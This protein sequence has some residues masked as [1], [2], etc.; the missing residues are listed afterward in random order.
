V[1]LAVQQANENLAE[2]QLLSCTM[3]VDDRR[4]PGAELRQLYLAADYPLPRRTGG[5]E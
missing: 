2:R 5:S 3:D 1:A 4:F